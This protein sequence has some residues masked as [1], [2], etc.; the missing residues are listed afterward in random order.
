MN[1]SIKPPYAIKKRHT[2]KLHGKEHQ[3]HYF[4][5]RDNNWPNIKDKEI[6]NHLIAE[7]KYTTA[8]LENHQELMDALCTEMQGRLKE[9]DTSY[10]IKDSGY[11][12]YNRTE[13]NKDYT[14]YCRRKNSIQSKE[15]ILLDINK[16]ASGSDSF[17]LGVFT[18]SHQKGL[19]A[20]SS[21]KDGKERYKIYIKN[22]SSNT[23]I[24]SNVDN[25]IGN[26]VWHRYRHGFFYLKLD[27]DW[28]HKEVYFHQLNTPQDDDIMVYTEKDITFSV[29]I[30]RS[31]DRKL[32]L[33]SSSSGTSD[34][35]RYL[36]FT[37]PLHDLKMLLPRKEQQKYSIDHAHQ[38]FYITIN[39][40]GKNFR[41]AKFSDT[42]AQDKNKWKEIIAHNPYSYL[43]S[44]SLNQDYLLINCKV[45]GIDKIEILNKNKVRKKIQF[46]EQIFSAEGYL[47]IY[48]S[49][50][51]II[52]YSS[53]TTP[54]TIFEYNFSQAKL[55][56]RKIKKIP[57]LFNTNDYIS[58][59][60]YAKAKDGI[61]IPISLVYN[62]NKISLNKTSPLY[63]YGYGSY[64]VGIDPSFNINALSLLDRGF[65]FA[66]AH[67]RGGDDLGYQWYKSAKFLTKKLTFSDFI[68]CAETLIQKK[69][70]NTNQLVI[71]G[72]SAGGMLMGVV[73][74]ERP[75]LFK[76]VIARVPFVDVLNTMSDPSLPL[77][78]GE[79]KEWGNPADLEYHNYITSYCPY[80]NIKKQKYPATFVTAGLTDPRV[81][82]WEPAKW[83]AKLREYTVGNNPILL[84]T[85]MSA[86]HRG[87]TGRYKYLHEVAKIYSFAIK[88]TIHPGPTSRLHKI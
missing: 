22:L 4:W 11:Y 64:G 41:L 72:G 33:I 1:F 71:S 37:S 68:T 51:A 35:F 19:L 40:L 34:E 63:L 13:K 20:Y 55:L 36:N 79:F 54:S 48:D 42:N 67:I 29:G 15:E 70:T 27:N 86:G 77:T 44:V 16:L 52:S 73:I 32:L 10:P 66:I 50:L 28:R 65:I 43:T 88:M 24:D 21:D 25:T 5:L 47:P 57:G 38:S 2:I 45:N 81:T 8:Y 78:P 39:D 82:Y 85:E 18:I 61:N 60:I 14:I 75:E 80:K 76:A 6:I 84:D 69:Y 7:N 17:N 49:S 83:V 58:K 59:R 56:K 62:K 12:Y 74:N 23:I 30:M 87:K 26:I 3:D 53:L 9:K 31:S 46:T